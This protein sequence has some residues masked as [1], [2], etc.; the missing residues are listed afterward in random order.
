MWNSAF[1]FSQM[2]GTL[3]V[4]SWKFCTFFISPRYATCLAHFI[5]IILYLGKCIN[6]EILS[7]SPT[8]GLAL[9]I[10]L[11]TLSSHSPSFQSV[12]RRTKFCTLSTERCGWVTGTHVFYSECQLFR[13][14]PRTWLSSSIFLCFP[15][16]HTNAWTL[17]YTGRRHFRCT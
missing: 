13:L 17:L 14:P 2:L 15:N 8:P 7:P 11:F 12:S 4:F 16:S 5:F 9:T 3:Q 1:H 10:Q 6:F